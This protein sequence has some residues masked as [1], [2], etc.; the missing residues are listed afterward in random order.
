MQYHDNSL[1]NSRLIKLNKIKELGIDPYP[2]R[3]SRT[4]DISTAID[5]F[6]S[7]ESESSSPQNNEKSVTLAGRII[8]IRGMGKAKFIDIR[9]YSETIQVLFRSNVLGE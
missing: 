9:D 8:A 3:Y 5:D 7:L 1:I 4:S 2:A 6:V